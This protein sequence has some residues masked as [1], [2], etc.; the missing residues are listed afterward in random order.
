MSQNPPFENLKKVKNR[1]KTC[2]NKRKNKINMMHY[3]ILS[4]FQFNVNKKIKS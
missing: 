2:H 1:L 3:Q 4:H